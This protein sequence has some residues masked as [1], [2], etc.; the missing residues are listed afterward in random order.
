MR[1]EEEPLYRVENGV[2]LVELEL[3]RIEQLFNTLDPSPFHEKDLDADAE[4]FIF[5]AVEEISLSR[6]V[7]LVIHVPPDEVSPGK[8][9]V[10]KEAL[11]HYFAYRSEITRRQL[12][13]IFW[14]ARV[15]LLIG[16]AFL[17]ACMGLQHALTRFL[18]DS[19]WA[20]FLR[21][22]LMIS[23]WVAMW[24]PIQLFLYDWWPHRHRM[25]TYRKISAMDVD[26]R[27]RT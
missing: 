4:E 20:Y 16:A 2:V 6:P 26:V 3:G 17:F 23:G 9:L 21:E 27:A 19:F 18:P 13:H 1:A 8:Q 14:L 22:G 11:H 24:R 5:E 10:V 12:R 15:S 7:R 25:M